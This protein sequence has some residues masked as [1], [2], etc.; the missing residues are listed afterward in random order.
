MRTGPRR[1]AQR[2]PS[3]ISMTGSKLRQQ[4]VQVL[5][6]GVLF[7][8]VAWLNDWLFRQLEFAPGINLVYLPAG[9]RLLCTLLF[10]EA[11]AVGLLLFSWWIG[12]AWYFPNDFMRAFMGGIL[13]ALAPYLVYRVAHRAWGFDATLRN[14][15]PRRLLLLALLYSLANPLLHHLWFAWRGQDDL[16]RGFAAMAVGD[17]TGTLILL[18]ALRAVLALLPRRHPAR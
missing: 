15:T 4:A 8:T 5:A 18:Y 7:V 14:L 11:G 9:I 6:T 3:A 17:L 1:R 12:F 13:T 16:L 2:D 10:G